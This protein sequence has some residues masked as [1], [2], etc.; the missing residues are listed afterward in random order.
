MVPAATHRPT[1]HQPATACTIDAARTA[2]NLAADAILAVR[3]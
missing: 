2:F 1:T 3:S